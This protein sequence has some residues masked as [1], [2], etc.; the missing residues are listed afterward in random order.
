MDTAAGVTAIEKSLPGGT[1]V[2]ITLVACAADPDPVT[3]NM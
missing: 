3:F 1:M 2:I